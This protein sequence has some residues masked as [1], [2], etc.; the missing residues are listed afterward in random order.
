MCCA[1]FTQ[2]TSKSF[3]VAKLQNHSLDFPTKKRVPLVHFGGPSQVSST[4]QL[5]SAQTR[6][7]C[8][9]ASAKVLKK[10]KND[11][12]VFLGVLEGMH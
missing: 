4:N 10:E 8:S 9:Q 5:L 11:D 2:T 12:D 6:L 3:F 1:L 7:L